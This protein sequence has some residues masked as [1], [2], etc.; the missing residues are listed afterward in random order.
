MIINPYSYPA[1]SGPTT[2]PT[3]VASSS[4]GST[5]STSRSINL[6]ISAGSDRALVVWVTLNSASVTVTGVTWNTSENLTF[7]GRTTGSSQ[8]VEMW[9]L[10]NP[11]ETFA[12]AVVS[13][14]GSVDVWA[15]A[16]Y[17]TGVD[18]SAPTEN[19]DG[20]S[21]SS[22]T[23]STTITSNTGSLVVGGFSWRGS[24]YPPFPAVGGDQTLI[25][26]F[27]FGE[28]YGFGM[29]SRETGAPSTTHSYTVGSSIDWIIGGASIKGL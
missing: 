10:V 4:H 14:S 17:Y 26:E 2:P 19:Y 29:T 18:Q 16:M 3:L 23:A 12:Q 1:A 25:E 9:V 28:A 8:T 15:D 6:T 11:T 27:G 21:G 22:T 7:V 24:G 20:T 13:L 5:A